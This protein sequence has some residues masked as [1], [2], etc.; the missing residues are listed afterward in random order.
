MVLLNGGDPPPWPLVAR[1]PFN[2]PFPTNF[3]RVHSVAMAVAKRAAMQ[4]VNLS[5]L[6]FSDQIR[7]DLRIGA[8]ILVDPNFLASRRWSVEDVDEDMLT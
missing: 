8:S 6:K 5:N 3:S 1:F 2:V 4:Y 7:S